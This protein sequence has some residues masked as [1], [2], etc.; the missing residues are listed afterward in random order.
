MKLDETLKEHSYTALHK[1][2]Y[3]FIYRN[4]FSILKITPIGKSVKYDNKEQ[5]EKFFKL[6]YEIRYKSNIMDQ[7]YLIANM[8]E[9]PIF[10]ENIYSTT[11][12][13]ST[14]IGIHTAS[15]K[16][17]KKDNLRI[18]VILCIISKGT[19]LPPLIIF[20]GE[21]NKAKEKKLHNNDFV[22]KGFCFV[23]CQPNSWA[24]N[25]LFIYI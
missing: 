9:I 22:K 10:Y 15:V 20:K 4:G 14:N 5:L 12:L 11:Q 3:R 21:T 7:L 24:D 19:K 2:L 6:L 8:E 18:T 13:L 16:N 25:N 23:K 17:F 1:R